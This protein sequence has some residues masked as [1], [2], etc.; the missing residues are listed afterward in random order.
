MTNINIKIKHQRKKKDKNKASV[1]LNKHTAIE[2][3]GYIN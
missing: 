1:K 2:N 3:N